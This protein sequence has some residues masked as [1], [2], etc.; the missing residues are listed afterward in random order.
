MSGTTCTSKARDPTVTP[1]TCDT[2]SF[3]VTVFFGAV[4]PCSAAH[5][6]C[7]S[8]TE[9]C[10]WFAS[11]MPCYQPVLF[12]AQHHFTSIQA[13]GQG[14]TDLICSKRAVCPEGKERGSQKSKTNRKSCGCGN[15]RVWPRSQQVLAARALP[16]GHRAIAC[17]IEGEDRGQRP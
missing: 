4:K 6:S 1:A 16:L 8:V 7:G 17:L 13:P 11:R 14:Y 15:P 10:P 9:P 2:A 3:P 12:L 5:P